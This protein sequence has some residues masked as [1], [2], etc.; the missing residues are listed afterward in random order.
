MTLSRD[1]SA[2]AERL[3]VEGLRRMSG[4]ERLA[5]AMALREATLTLARVRI[6]ERRGDIP[7]REVRLRLASLWLDR[8]TMIRVFDWDPQEKGL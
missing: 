4:T 5:R 3:L 2:R 8:A 1:T 7:E 6:R